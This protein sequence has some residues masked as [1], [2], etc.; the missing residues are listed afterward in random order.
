MTIY[1]HCQYILVSMT[2]TYAQWF[3]EHF[4]S[5]NQSE[6]VRLYH[7]PVNDRIVTIETHNVPSD[8]PNDKQLSTI[9]IHQNIFDFRL[10]K[11]NRKKAINVILGHPDL[12]NCKRI[13]IFTVSESETEIWSR[14]MLS[15]PPV[16]I[17]VKNELGTSCPDIVKCVTDSRSTGGIR[18]VKDNKQ[19]EF[20]IINM[21][22]RLRGIDGDC[23]IIYDDNTRGHITYNHTH[24]ITIVNF[25]TRGISYAFSMNI[26]IFFFQ[27]ISGI[28]LSNI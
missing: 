25:I 8:D 21:N 20:V 9:R 12:L 4:S 28:P 15:R 26:P 22:H 23:I 17:N 16:T 5:L 1:V 3:T 14:F 7:L 6:T 27:N 2:T 11:I 18:K 13:L 10:Q 24:P 19:R